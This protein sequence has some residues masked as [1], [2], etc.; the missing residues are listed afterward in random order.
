LET[1]LSQQAAEELLKVLPKIEERID[2]VK[3]PQ[4]VDELRAMLRSVDLGIHGIELKLSEERA[5]TYH[6]VA[7][8]SK[9]TPTEIME[10]FSRIVDDKEED[11]EIPIG[12]NPRHSSRFEGKELKYYKADKKDHR[13][14]PEEEEEEEDEYDGIEQEGQGLYEK[15]EPK[16]IKSKVKSLDFDKQVEETLTGASYGNVTFTKVSLHNGPGKKGY[17]RARI[18]KKDGVYESDFKLGTQVIYAFTTKDLSY[19]VTDNQRKIYDKFVKDLES[20]QEERKPKISRKKKEYEDF[21]EVIEDLNRDLTM[22][23]QGNNSRILA[24]QIMKKIQYLEAN[25]V[26]NDAE[27]ERLINLM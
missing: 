27:V 9:K 10:E 6:T 23:L 1:P 18:D 17:I 14:E 5:P 26:I 7:S 15:S 20:F 13:Y 11:D 24:N 2:N 19:L 21:D 3:D 8:E 12:P 25:E 16:M 22:Y 4:Y